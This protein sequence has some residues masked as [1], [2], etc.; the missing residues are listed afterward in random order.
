MAGEDVDEVYDL[1][2]DGKIFK[3]RR[4]F[5]ELPQSAARDGNRLFV[6]GL[7]ETSGD[8]ARDLLNAAIRSDLDGKYQ[9][10]AHYRMLQLA[11]AD[12]DTSTVLSVGAAFLDR[13]EMSKYRERI[14]AMLAAHAPEGSAEQERFLRLLSGESPGSYY[15]RLAALTEALGAMRARKYESAEAVCRHIIDSGD[16]N[17][18]PAGLTLLARIA[19]AR[20][21][22]ERALLNYNI[23]REKYPDAVGQDEL[24]QELKDVSERRSGVESTE[25][26]DGVAYTV[27]VGVFADK[28]N[29]KRMKQRIEAYGYKARISKRSVSGNTYNFVLAGRFT[30]LKEAR[31]AK[32]KLEMGENE[33]FKVVIDDEK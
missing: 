25:T 3:A 1:Y 24:L 13:W 29:A 7:L 20:E 21:N 27:Q 28:D 32:E 16:D 19:L 31:M 11:E 22:T 8:R 30:T 26:Y 15:G 2:R 33:V 10:E 4:E 17:I 18:I 12:G 6:G 9:E 14:L 23:I 5:Q